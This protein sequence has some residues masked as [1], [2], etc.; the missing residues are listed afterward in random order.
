MKEGKM[1]EPS[2]ME[3]TVESYTATLLGEEDIHVTP[4]SKKGKALEEDKVLEPSAKKGT[5]E[6]Y[7]ANVTNLFHVSDNDDNSSQEG[8]F[9]FLIHTHHQSD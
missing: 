8:E 6:S 4:E 3:G 1:L 2:A 9:C 7:T 5:V